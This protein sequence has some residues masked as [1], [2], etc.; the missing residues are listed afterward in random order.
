MITTRL[1]RDGR[2]VARCQFEKLIIGG[3]IL[4]RLQQFPKPWEQFK[5]S[6]PR[7]SR[8][9]SSLIADCPE[10]RLALAAVNYC[11][12]HNEHYKQVHMLNKDGSL[13]EQGQ[14]FVDIT[15]QQ[16]L[17][18]EGDLQKYSQ[19]SDRALASTQ[20]RMTFTVS[21]RRR[22]SF[23]QCVTSSSDPNTTFQ[24]TE[25]QDE[26]EHLSKTLTGNNKVTLDFMWSQCFEESDPSDVWKSLRTYRDHTKKLIQA[27]AER[28]KE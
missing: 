18:N 2:V 28:R 11:E 10:E 16:L 22:V 15:F 23:E 3:R 9:H 13:T 1:D 27:L 21:K 17:D 25:L 19:R 12:S 24:K 5:H 7:L 4:E 26:V 6:L 20:H 8:Y 14:S